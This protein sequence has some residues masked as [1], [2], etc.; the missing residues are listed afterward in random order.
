MIGKKNVVFGFLFLALS[1]ILG[2]VMIVK[3]IPDV[4]ATATAKQEKI[5]FLQQ[6]AESGFEVDLEPMD[7]KTLAQ[8]NTK[9]VLALSA[10]LNSQSAMDMIKGG[11]HAHGNLEA[12]LNIVVGI[13]LGFVAAKRLFKQIISWMFIIGTLMHA[14][15]L[16]ASRALGQGWADSI[17]FSPVG[18]VGPA[19]IVLGLVL[20]GVIAITGFRGEPVRDKLM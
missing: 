1:A 10:D 13:F 20:C 9:A 3:Y 11:P 14:G 18:P 8:A 17:M 2:P 19:L 15:L 7:A 6:A 12:L 16:Y 5:G 4:Q